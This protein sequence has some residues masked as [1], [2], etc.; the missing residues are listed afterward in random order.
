MTKLEAL[1]CPNCNNATMMLHPQA[2]IYKHT[3][4]NNLYKCNFCSY[5]TCITT[6]EDKAD[7]MPEREYKKQRKP[8]GE[9]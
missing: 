1:F 7:D 4:F 9:E 5:T 8:F 2:D 3:K 6:H